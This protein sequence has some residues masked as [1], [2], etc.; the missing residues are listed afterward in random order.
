M[1]LVRYW[2][3]FDEPVSRRQYLLFGLVLTLTKY[4]GDALLVFMATRRLWT[5]FDYL[6][7]SRTLFATVF[8]GVPPWLLPILVLWALPFIWIGVTL[9]MRRAIDA[10]LSPWLGL[11]F[12]APYVNY[13]LMAVLCVV[14]G[15]VNE[16]VPADAPPPSHDRRR[17]MFSAF[18]A[19]LAIGIPMVLMS[20]TL[21]GTYG[22][23]LFFGTPFAIGAASGFV[24]NRMYEAPPSQTMGV[25]WMTFLVCG[26]AALLFSIEGAVCIFMEFPLAMTVGTFGGMMG[27]AIAQLG[28]R[29]LKPMMFGLLAI[30]LAIAFEPA[31]STGRVAHEVRSS[32]EIDAPPS[33]VWDHV[34]AFK[35]ISE[36]A[37]VLFRTGIAYPQYARIEGAGVGAVRYCVFSTGAFVEP[38]TA[39]EPGA[40]LAFDVASS[41]PP[42]REWSIYS[43]VK[44]PHLDGFLR[45]KRGEFRL[46]ALPDGRT[47][48]EGSTWYQIEMAPEGY[49]QLYSDYLIHRIH[50]RVLDHIKTETEQERR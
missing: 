36:P 19:G 37:E 42:L 38:I 3:R 47:R 49:W 20:V 26:V 29:D 7:S 43:N 24:Y 40:R 11:I 22:L 15:A 4:T 13:L 35:R 30:P 2:T 21:L 50:R 28:R 6:A 9:T 12:F 10:G 34:I 27:R 16:P 25:V 14:P 8:H 41:P 32:V 48:L 33:H 17:A 44:P 31:G 18:A 1:N 46:V 45:S 23:G 5:P 39:W